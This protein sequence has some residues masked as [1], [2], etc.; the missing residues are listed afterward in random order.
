MTALNVIFLTKVTLKNLLSQ[1]VALK[2]INIG[3]FW[4]NSKLKNPARFTYLK[5]YWLFLKKNFQRRI[6]VM[7]AALDSDASQ[8]EFIWF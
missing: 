7:A 2:K 5:P 4:F 8:W 1:K 6:E 3:P